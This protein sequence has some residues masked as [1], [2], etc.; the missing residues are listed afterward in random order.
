[1]TATF[2]THVQ[3]FQKN[4]FLRLGELVSN[5]KSHNST[6]FA[7]T[8]ED[9]TTQLQSMIY[10]LSRGD[11]KLKLVVTD[12]NGTK[13]SERWTST[14]Q[15]KEGFQFLVCDMSNLMLEVFCDGDSI[16]LFD[17]VG[18][19]P[20]EQMPDNQ[21]AQIALQFAQEE[22]YNKM[23]NINNSVIKIKK[24]KEAAS[25]EASLSDNEELIQATGFEFVELEDAL[26]ALSPDAPKYRSLQ[27]HTEKLQKAFACFAPDDGKIANLKAALPPSPTLKEEPPIPMA[28]DDDID[29]DAPP[30]KAQCAAD[31]NA[32]SYRSLCSAE[33]PPVYHA[34]YQFK[35]NTALAEKAAIQIE[36]K[37]LI[38]EFE[39]CNEKALKE[40]KMLENRQKQDM[41]VGRFELV[42]LSVM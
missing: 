17:V 6:S 42:C 39:S 2:K 23:C 33:T 24:E 4:A 28:T 36:N 20:K 34:Q 12:R 7:L 22:A 14:S 11:R 31:N 10:K 26:S 13:E 5:C 41:E 18:S 3:M 35:L 29:H 27:A 37:K 32:T 8:K 30:S 9:L 19:T 16:V 40:I 21:Q 25:G 38:A 1:M 15:L